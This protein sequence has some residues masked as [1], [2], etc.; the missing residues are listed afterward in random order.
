MGKI[1]IETRKIF[2]RLEKYEFNFS[3]ILVKAL[4]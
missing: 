1:E 2:I 3:M 4:N